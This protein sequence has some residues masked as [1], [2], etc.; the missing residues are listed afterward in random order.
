MDNAHIT[1]VGVAVNGEPRPVE[2]TGDVTGRRVRD[3][4]I[5]PSKLLS[6]A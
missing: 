3:L 5:T 1:H 6:S 2:V 4:P